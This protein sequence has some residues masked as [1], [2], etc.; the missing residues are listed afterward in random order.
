MNEVNTLRDTLRPHFAWHGA[1]L[2]LLAAFLMALT[3]VRTVNLA[4]LAPHWSARLT[5][6]LSTSVYNDFSDILS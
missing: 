4:E 6:N 2:N 5:K 3:Q 1:R